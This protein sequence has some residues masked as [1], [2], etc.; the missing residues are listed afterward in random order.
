MNEGKVSLWA[1]FGE[2]GVTSTHG[3]GL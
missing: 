2:G 3:E 1:W